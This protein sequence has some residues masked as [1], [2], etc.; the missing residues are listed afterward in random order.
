MAK[1]FGIAFKLKGED[2]AITMAKGKQQSEAD[3]NSPFAEYGFGIK[4]WINTLSFLFNLYVVLSVFAFAIMKLYEG[5]NGLVP[6]AGG[7]GSLTKY[8]LG[9]IGFAH[10]LCF[11]QYATI[12][13]PLELKCQ[14]GMLSDI[15][16]KG[17]IS[18]DEN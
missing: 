12:K 4:A 5:F 14:T 15:H 16:F 13:Q 1:K 10:S 6:A 8:S 18:S 11:F 17:A 2:K 3:K 7:F 9:N